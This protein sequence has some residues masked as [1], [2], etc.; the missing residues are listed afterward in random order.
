MHFRRAIGAVSA[1]EQKRL[2]AVMKQLKEEI[3]A[4]DL[5]LVKEHFDHMKVE[6]EKDVL[7]SERDTALFDVN[8]AQAHCQSIATQVRRGRLSFAQR[9]QPRPLH[10]GLPPTALPSPLPRSS[11]FPCSPCTDPENNA[12]HERKSFQSRLPT[13]KK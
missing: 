3:G 10:R 2:D 12:R 1:H 5:A 7:T 4:K 8:V 11:P 9:Q 13:K 6:K